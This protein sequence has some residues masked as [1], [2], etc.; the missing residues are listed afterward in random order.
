MAEEKKMIAGRVKS[1]T[2]RCKI[3]AQTTCAGTKEEAKL[4]RSV[5][6]EF[7]NLRITLFS[8]R[9]TINAA[10]FKLQVAHVVL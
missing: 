7:I 4:A 10:V 5:G 9:V 2:Y 3:N 6:I 1:S 8:F